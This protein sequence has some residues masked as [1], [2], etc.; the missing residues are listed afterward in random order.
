M[1]YMDNNA[2]TAPHREVIE[3]M[4]NCLAT[5]FGNASSRHPVGRQARESLE[6]A[7]CAFSTVLTAAPDEVVFTSGGTESVGLAFQCGLARGNR[8]MIIG[9]TEHASVLDAAASWK[10]R[11]VPIE[12]LAVDQSGVPDLEALDRMLR[13][14]SP[15]FVSLI[16]VNNE[17]G[18][19]TPAA[20]VSS[21]CRSNGALLHLDAVQATGRCR[22]DLASTGCD[23]LSLSAH[24]F[25]GPKGVGILF[26]RTSAPLYPLCP[27]N[28]ERGLRGGTENVPAIVG[29]AAALR[30]LRDWEAESLRQAALRDRLELG[31][32]AAIQESEVNG[33]SAVRI[34]NTSNIYF[35]NRNAA[36]LVSLLGVKGLCV[37]AGAACSSGDGKPSHVLRAMGHSLE[38][39]NGS[40]RFSLGRNTTDNDVT[41]AIRIVSVV[42]AS[43]LPTRGTP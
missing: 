18:V 32:S 27:G 33:R 15:A 21:I 37:S 10:R 1:I 23:Y 30:V 26:A 8:R 41:E 22:I 42:Y 36:D 25:Q 14:G 6:L 28:Q 9:A 29:A 35:P 3:A 13:K 11:G 19:V 24:K 7:R 12:L 34:A 31:I 5:N 20:E 4:C 39:A 16:W 40:V 38:R 17:T 2:T 43:S